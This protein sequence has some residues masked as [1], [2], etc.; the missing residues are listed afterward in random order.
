MKKT[1]LN[2][3]LN[4]SLA[5]DAQLRRC[6][7]PREPKKS[8]KTK[9]RLRRH[10]ADSILALVRSLKTHTTRTYLVDLPGVASRERD[11]VR[12]VVGREHAADGLDEL[13]ELALLCQA[14]RVTHNLQDVVHGDKLHLDKG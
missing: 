10:G 7:E 9:K 6:P 13:L 14:G 2:S 5:A 11:V 4:I 3:N 1:P 12:A 8:H